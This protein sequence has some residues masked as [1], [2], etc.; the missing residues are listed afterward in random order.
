MLVVAQQQIT[1]G[2]TATFLEALSL[3]RQGMAENC[4]TVIK[5][6]SRKESYGWLGEVDQLEEFIDTVNAQDLS[7]LGPVTVAGDLSPFEGTNKTYVGALNIKQADIEDDQYGGLRMRTMDLATRAASHTDKLLDDLLLAGETT[8]CYDTDYMFTASHP[9]RR[10]SGSQSNLFTGTGTTTALVMADI[11]SALTGLYNLLDEAGEPAN[12]AF[13]EFVICYAPV[14]HRPIA[15][16]VGAAIV[17]QTSNVQFLGKNITLMQRPRLTGT[18]DA[19]AHS[20][21]IMIKDAPVRGMIYQDRLP[22][23][24]TAQENAGD[25]AFDKE[26]W[27]YKVR[28]RGFALPG[29]WQRIC[30][31]S[32]T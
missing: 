2:L 8:L 12:E 22:P 21:Y 14:M 30:K 3:P 4:A 32:N 5:S 31:V 11:G 19:M 1:K 27:K 15:E 28:K 7:E 13:T 24:F 25:D 20:Y 9:A 17:A 6:T 10:S 16:A 23:T 18:T 29:R 26:I